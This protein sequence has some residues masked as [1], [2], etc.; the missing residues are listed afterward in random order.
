M[1]NM[2]TNSAAGKASHT[3]VMPNAADKT[4]AKMVIATNPRMIDATN[5]YFTDSTALNIASADE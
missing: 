5:A 2:V 3:P 1:I 4:N